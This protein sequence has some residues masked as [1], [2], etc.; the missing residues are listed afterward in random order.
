M[1]KTHFDIFIIV[2]KALVLKEYKITCHS[3]VTKVPGIAFCDVSVSNV[4]QFSVAWTC[5][6]VEHN[7]VIS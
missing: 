2:S 4:S 6:F 5:L 1:E 7:P 3:K